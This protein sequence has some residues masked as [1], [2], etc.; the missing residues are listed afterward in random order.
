MSLNLESVQLECTSSLGESIACC[1]FSQSSQSHRGGTQKLV[2]T[3]GIRTEKFDLNLVFNV[4][5]AKISASN[6]N[7]IVIIGS[8]LSSLNLR[9]EHRC[10]LAECNLSIDDEE[11]KTATILQLSHG[12]EH[13]DLGVL[14][15]SFLLSGDRDFTWILPLWVSERLSHGLVAACDDFMQGEDILTD[16]IMACQVLRLVIVTV[17]DLDLVL[18]ILLE[19]EFD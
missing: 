4:V 15:G 1:S 12:V 16:E 13:D 2:L 8:I 7:L 9:L 3:R 11:A 14:V 17:V 6:L 19:V 5:L 10:E 18:F